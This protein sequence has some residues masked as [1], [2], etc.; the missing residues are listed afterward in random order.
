[1]YVEDNTK[2]RNRT[3]AHELHTPSPNLYCS[4]QTVK[5]SYAIAVCVL[6]YTHGRRRGKHTIPTFNQIGG[7]VFTVAGASTR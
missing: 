5:T 2:G 1:M 4:S 7:R 3:C 6:N